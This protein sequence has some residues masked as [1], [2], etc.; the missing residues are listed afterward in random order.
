MK[1][2]I[3]KFTENVYAVVAAI[4]CGKVLTYGQVACLVGSP[5]HSRLVGRVLHGASESCSLPCHRVVSSTGRTVPHWPEQVSL[6]KAE[7]VVFR[8]NGCV[9]MVLSNWNFNLYYEE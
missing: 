8:S 3:E 1:V 9:D 4:P 2:D 7:S 6:L 5:C